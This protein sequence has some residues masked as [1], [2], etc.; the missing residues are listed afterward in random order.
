MKIKIIKFD[1]YKAPDRAHYNDSGADIFAAKTMD[2]EPGK[3]T[4]V[5]VKVG[6]K[7]E[8][9]DT[10]AIIEAMKMETEIKSQIGRAS[11]RERV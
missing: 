6:D 4:K 2:L 5:L 11:C 7:I 3:I 1:N 8:K 10:V 9:E